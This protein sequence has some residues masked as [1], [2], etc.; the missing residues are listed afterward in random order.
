[1]TKAEQAR[2]WAWRWKVT[3]EVNPLYGQPGPL[4]TNVAY[5]PRMGQLGVRVAF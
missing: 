3:A 1:M 4:P 2:L 5:Q